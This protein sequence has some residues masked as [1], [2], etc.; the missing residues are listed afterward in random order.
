[1]GDDLPGQ[2]AVK[3]VFLR[4]FQASM[5]LFGAVIALNLTVAFLRPLLP[6][7]IGGLAAASVAWLVVVFVRW[8]RSRW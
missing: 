3:N 4:V 2:S 7:F 5:L 6:W 8:R 1:M